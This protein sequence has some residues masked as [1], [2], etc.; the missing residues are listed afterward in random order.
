M[1]NHNTSRSCDCNKIRLWRCAIE[2]VR[3]RKT[4]ALNKGDFSTGSF[5]HQAEKLLM[6]D[7]RKIDQGVVDA[8]IWLEKYIQALITQ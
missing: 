3:Q 5:W 1:V 4:F 7:S 2:E 8:K 6:G